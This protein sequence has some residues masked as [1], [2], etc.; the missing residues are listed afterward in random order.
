MPKYLVKVLYNPEGA[1]GLMKN[2]GTARRTVADELI[3]KAGGEDGSLLLRI[4]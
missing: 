1:R 2:G 4:R 3:Q